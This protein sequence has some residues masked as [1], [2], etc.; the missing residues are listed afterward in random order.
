MTSIVN[1]AR[2]GSQL[3]MLTFTGVPST[4]SQARSAASAEAR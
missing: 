4:Y 1:C 3:E 2:I